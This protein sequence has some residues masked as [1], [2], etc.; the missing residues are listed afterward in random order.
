MKLKAVYKNYSDI[1]SEFRELY[2]EIGNEYVLSVDDSDYK[3]RISEFRNNNI[4]L[5]RQ[6]E[7][8]KTSTEK[9]SV[10]EEQLQRYSGLDPDQAREA[11]ARMQE[12]SDK[13]LIE[14]GKIDELLNQRTDRMRSDYEGK[15]N[16]LTEALENAR[17]G[18]QT[19]KSKLTEVVVDSQLQSAINAIAPAKRGAMEYILS[20][21]RQ[22]WTLGENNEPVPLGADGK[23]IYGKDPQKVLSME[24]WAQGLLQES[25]YLF[26]QSSGGGSSGSNSGQ[27]IGKTI[28]LSDTDAISANLEAIAAGTVSVS[29]D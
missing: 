11:V 8:M 29:Q 21:G 20:K 14:E 13:K 22:T 9:M 28:H 23:V 26:E 6:L 17:G 4:E 7:N 15:I 2:S 27:T 3:N 25:P 19:L 18:E 16:A 5:S 12:L 24:E 1:P 10:L